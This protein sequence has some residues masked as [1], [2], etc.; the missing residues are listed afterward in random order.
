MHPA[1]LLTATLAVPG[2]NARQDD[3]PW[4]TDLDAASA[5]AAKA[6]KPLLVVFR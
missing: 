5:E 1:L 2:S 3:V 4:R 6:D